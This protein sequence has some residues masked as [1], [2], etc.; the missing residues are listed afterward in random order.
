LRSPN[1]ELALIVLH[2]TNER[3]MIAHGP[4]QTSGAAAVGPVLVEVLRHYDVVVANVENVLGLG[5]R[6][7]YGGP[8]LRIPAYELVTNEK[9]FDGLRDLVPPV[10]TLRGFL[11]L[12]DLS[13]RVLK[14]RLQYPAIQFHLRPPVC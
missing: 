11:E 5:R 3:A 4:E 14:G 8:S 13:K 9:S 12:F 1:I 10:L 2:H 7:H 6:P